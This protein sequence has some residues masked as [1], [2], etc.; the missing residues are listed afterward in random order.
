MVLWV[1][2]LQVRW[3]KPAGLEPKSE[4]NE[5]LAGNITNS[6]FYSNEKRKEKK[7]IIGKLHHVANYRQFN[8]T[9]LWHE[10]ICHWLEKD[11]Y[12]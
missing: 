1:L 4:V 2:F 10:D 6:T 8:Q 3:H 9:V 11:A 12:V 5:I 7:K